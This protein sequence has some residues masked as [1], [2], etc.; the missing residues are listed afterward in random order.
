LLQVV[1]AVDRITELMKVLVAVEQVDFVQLLVQLV[2]V[3]HL[4]LHYL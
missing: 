4:N 3:D 1:V 2:A